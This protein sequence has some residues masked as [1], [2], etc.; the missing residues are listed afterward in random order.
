[1]TNKITARN[2]RAKKLRSN[3]INL[4]INRLSI[5]RSSQHMYAQIFSKDGT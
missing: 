1:M 2:R 5:F 3:S 4:S